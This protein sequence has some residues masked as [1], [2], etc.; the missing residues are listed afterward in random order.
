[1]G[2]PGRHLSQLGFSVK[3]PSGYDN[4]MSLLGS[5]NISSFVYDLD[6]R[7]LMKLELDPSRTRV[8]P[9]QQNID[10]LQKNRLHSC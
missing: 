5:M 9:S 6:L 7:G 8:Q 2:D 3:L 10:I 4:P 1:M